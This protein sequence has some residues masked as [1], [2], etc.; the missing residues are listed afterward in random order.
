MQAVKYTMVQITA[1]SPVV[2]YAFVY[3]LICG[4]LGVSP[5]SLWI[6]VVACIALGVIV[7]ILKLAIVK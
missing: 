7:D 1:M 6:Y 5:W 4:W 2:G 3:P